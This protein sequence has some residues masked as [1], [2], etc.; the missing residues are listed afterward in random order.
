MTGCLA[1]PEKESDSYSSYIVPQSQ[2]II[3]NPMLAVTIKLSRGRKSVV[4][5]G[6]IF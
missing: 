5:T 4:A 1:L 3:K 6:A 2:E